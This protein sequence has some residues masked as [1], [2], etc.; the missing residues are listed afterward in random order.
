MSKVGW[1]DL[2]THISN[3]LSSAE[4]PREYLIR[5]R[6]ASLAHKEELSQKY[7]DGSLSEQ[8]Q[9]SLERLRRRQ[10]GNKESSK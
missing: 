6:A 10:G 4:N 1:R 8:I 2:K 5:A 3:G 7:S 9:E